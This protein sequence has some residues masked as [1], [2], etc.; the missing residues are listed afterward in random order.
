MS[1]NNSDFLTITGDEY[2]LPFATENKKQ[3]ATTKKKIISKLP[4]PQQSVGE[5]RKVVYHFMACP[6]NPQN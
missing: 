3:K 6:C 5:R 2:A 1:Q 4:T